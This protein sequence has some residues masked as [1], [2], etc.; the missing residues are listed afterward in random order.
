MPIKTLADVTAI[1][2]TPLWQRIAATSVYEQLQ[3]VAARL[4]DLLALRA[5]ATT[6][7]SEAPRDITFRDFLKKITQ[8]ANLLTSLGVGPTDVVSLMVP[9]VCDS[10][11]L[12]SCFDA[13]SAS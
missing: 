7:A 4:P 1:E 8:V 9:L 6:D 10:A 11:A 12:L 13:V 3:D 2:Q 5:V